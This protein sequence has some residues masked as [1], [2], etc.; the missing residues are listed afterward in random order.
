[1][2]G[3]V[4]RIIRYVEKGKAG[5]QL[6]EAKLITGLGL[7]GNIKQG[8]ERQLCL[9]SAQARSWMENQIEKGLCFDRFKENILV[10]G[11][12]LEELRNGDRLAIGEAV[13]RV[14][15]YAKKCFDEC[16]LF[17]KG[18]QCHLSRCA[19]FAAVE[20]GGII[21]AGD[22]QVLLKLNLGKFVIQ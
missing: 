17:R 5:E 21:R 2:N 6:D 20:R 16:A 11:L 12:P 1:M 19:V 7:E 4:A 3:K 15:G 18:I 22:R 13:L 10:D 14:S 8:G 9:L